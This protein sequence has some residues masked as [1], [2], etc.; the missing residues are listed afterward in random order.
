MYEYHER[1]LNFI[2]KLTGIIFILS[3]IGIY[4]K[5]PEYFNTL[6]LLVKLYI[7]LFLIFYFNP[8]STHRFTE[9][10]R[11][12]VFRAGIFLL[13]TTVT[14]H[15]AMWYTASNHIKNKIYTLN[16]SNQRQL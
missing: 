10:D 14:T 8:Y 7:S 11:G 2:F 13:L 5:A 9:F 1:I 15:L 16:Q 4:S 12:I 6:N 3:L